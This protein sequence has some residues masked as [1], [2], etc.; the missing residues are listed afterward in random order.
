[1]MFL[2]LATDKKQATGCYGA[3]FFYSHDMPRKEHVHSWKYEYVFR[4][5][6]ETILELH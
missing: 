1:M 2:T 5:Q 6:G 3:Y 4:G